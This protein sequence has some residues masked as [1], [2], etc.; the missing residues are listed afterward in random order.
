MSNPEK[1]YHLEWRAEDDRLADT[2]KKLLEKNGLPG[3]TYERKGQ[4]VVYLKQAEQISDM[5]AFMGAGAG[6]LKM[7]SIRVNRQTRLRA[8]RATNCDEHN[9]E[10]MLDAAQRQARA[11]RDISLRIGLFTLPP[12]LR[13][14]ARIR[15]E[16]PDLSLA[17]LGAMMD[18]H[19]SKSAVN[20][21][22]RWLTEIAEK[23]E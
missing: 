10:K 13:E 18:P 22:L 11:C 8:T 9:S 6:E 19:I 4:T 16:N 3:H 15:M 14:M 2:L 12:A 17:E 21:R 1:E 20:H 7:E 5:L 23:L